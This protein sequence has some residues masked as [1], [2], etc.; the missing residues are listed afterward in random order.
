MKALFRLTKSRPP[1]MVHLRR[2]VARSRRA[3]RGIEAACGKRRGRQA[4]VTDDR[5][6]VECGRCRRT[7]LYRRAGLFEGAA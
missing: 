3:P 1:M 7:R 4:L 2:D 5:G 6:I